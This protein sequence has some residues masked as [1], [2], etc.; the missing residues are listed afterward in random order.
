MTL[1]CA[2]R[3]STSRAKIGFVFARRGI[4]MEACSSYFLPR[5][6][7][8]S[9]ALHLVTTGATYP[10]S[11][12]LLSDLFSELLE[13]GERVLGRALEV[14]E[15]VAANTS[16]VSTAL[17]REMMWR[18][19]PTVEESHKLESRVL[20]ELFQG[21]DK[22]EG[23]RAFMEKRKVDFQGTMG[24]DAP[25]VYPWWEPADVRVEGKVVSADKSKL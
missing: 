5:L 24:K 14:A 22:E 17:M 2:I 18:G 16:V 6:I 1:P 15:E 11:S 8:Y 10:A 13:T 7:G 19:P 25:S 21:R 23:I 20:A 9:R 4:V 12:P 3:L